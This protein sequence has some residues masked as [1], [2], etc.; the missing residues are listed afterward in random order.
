MIKSHI[1]GIKGNSVNTGNI[2]REE[3]VVPSKIQHL[4]FQCG[5]SFLEAFG[6]ELRSNRYVQRYLNNKRIPAYA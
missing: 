5:K 1:H 6:T 3:H 2:R 4:C